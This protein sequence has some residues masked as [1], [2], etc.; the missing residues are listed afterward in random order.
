[1]VRS[2]GRK[3]A[4]K[5]KRGDKVK[6]GQQRPGTGAPTLGRGVTAR[7]SRARASYTPQLYLKGSAMLV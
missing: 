1:M 2:R 6:E 3:Q 5:A 7:T 4:R